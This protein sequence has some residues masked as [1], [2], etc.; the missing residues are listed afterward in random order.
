MGS[1]GPVPETAYYYP[2]PYW[3]AREG[4]WIKSLLLFFDEVAIL[5][6]SYMQ[7]RNVVADPT[8]AGPLEERGLLRVLQPEV[9]VDGE[10]ATELTAVVEALIHEGAFDELSKAGGFAE[11]SMSRMGFG[12]L[13]TVARRVLDQLSAR[14][15]AMPSQ[16]GVSI[17][18]HP[19]IRGIYLV[20]LAQLTRQA[21]VR[22]ELDL[23]PVTNGRGATEAFEQLADL[24][25]MPSRGQLVSLDLEVVSVDL[26]SVS[27]DEVLEF[28][29]ENGGE[30]RRYMENLRTFALELSLLEEVDRARALKDRQ[31]ELQEQASD[32]RKHALAAW[33]SPKDVTG[34]G[35]GL[36]GAAW[37]VAAHNPVPAALGILGAG[38]TMLPSGA[39]GSVYSYLF[40]A[41]RSMP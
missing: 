11:L 15:L 4:G 31:A 36:A 16:D 2:E 1:G 18:M 6:P 12:V 34:F 19:R 41:S 35:L 39:D 5:L 27:L 29:R 14:G 25:P 21:G 8:L 3:L 24:P 9:F 38:L 23:H 7:G 28:K 37:S 20:L 22:S 13:E 10:I 32:L 33:K 30:H 26:D 40:R 17:P